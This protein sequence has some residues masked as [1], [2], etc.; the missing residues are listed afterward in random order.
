MIHA[1]KESLKKQA[2]NIEQAC[3]KINSFAKRRRDKRGRLKTKE[4]T[5][6]ILTV[7]FEHGI[8]ANF[9]AKI[10]GHAIH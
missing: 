4:L 9:L 5:D 7:A 8:N 1:R 10:S 6:C 2:S 3:K